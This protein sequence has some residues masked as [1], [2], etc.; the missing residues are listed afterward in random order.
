[1]IRLLVGRLISLFQRLRADW[2]E[3]PKCGPL[4]R[5][6][7]EPERTAGFRGADPRVEW[8]QLGRL[9][10]IGTA[11]NQRPV[12]GSVRRAM[13]ER[14][15]VVPFITTRAVFAAAESAGDSQG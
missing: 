3:S 15:W 9:A 6:G 5:R 10:Y 2:P 8:R 14:D 11:M 4:A 1:M 13:N 12:S 7:G